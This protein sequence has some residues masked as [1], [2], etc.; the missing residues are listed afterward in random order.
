MSEYTDKRFK[1]KRGIN[2]FQKNPQNIKRGRTK[3][4]YTILK[5]K[6]YTLDDMRIAFGEMAWYSLEELK[7]IH[8][9]ETKPIIT[10]I[11]AN[12]FYLALK[13]GNWDKIKEILEHVIGK[14][15][16]KIDA[17]VNSSQMSQ[18]EFLDNLNKFKE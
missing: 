14:P 2:G 8:Q 1:G 10:R 11:V 18:E 6:G 13:G 16:Q 15:T 9:D 4:I 17:N 3:K 7:A 5:E 12:Q